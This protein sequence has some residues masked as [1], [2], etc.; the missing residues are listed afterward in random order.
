MKLTAGKRIL[1]F[2]YWLLSTLAC[3][4]LAAFLAVPNLMGGIRD[5]LAARLNAT[6]TVV[7]GFALLAVYAALAA[8]VLW[9]I[10]HREKGVERG[11]LDVVSGD[12]GH[13]RISVAAIEQMVRQSV[14][15]IDGIYEMKINIVNQG[16]AIDIEVEAIIVG[17]SHV[18]TVT[19]N[20]QRAIR[21]FV[22]THCGVSVREVSIS[23]DS[24]ATGH[25]PRNRWRRSRR[26]APTPL[27]EMVESPQPEASAPDAEKQVWEEAP[28]EDDV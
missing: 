7:A 22:E 19:M 8:A 10:F 17:G 28:G 21:Q 18:P 14:T 5:G 13:V 4:T 12:S 16:D 1:L 26:P 23:V 25:D 20:M 9:L 15:A 2:F 6:Q 27:P 3:A 24:V 11:F